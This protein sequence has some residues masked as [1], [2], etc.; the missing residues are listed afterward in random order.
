MLAMPAATTKVGGKEVA[1][2]V[3]YMVIFY[4]IYNIYITSS[5]A[6]TSIYLGFITTSMAKFS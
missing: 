4:L 3:P 5:F 2:N 1:Y 6:S